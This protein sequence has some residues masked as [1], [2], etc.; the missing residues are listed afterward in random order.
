MPQSSPDDKLAAVQIEVAELGKAVSAMVEHS[1]ANRAQR[2]SFLMAELREIKGAQK[3]IPAQPIKTWVNGLQLVIAVVVGV[4]GVGGIVFGFG[5]TWSSTNGKIEGANTRIATV[6]SELRLRLDT[7]KMEMTQAD[8]I[9]RQQLAAH[10]DQIRLLHT[11]DQAANERMSQVYQSLA[12]ITVQNQN[13]AERMA[14]IGRRQDR[15]EARLGLSRGN[16]NAQP[17]GMGD[18]GL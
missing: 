6:E 8:A 18:N 13:L 5:Q 10:T 2:D 4:F 7:A 17:S 1:Q 15:L 3:A 11:T 14:E 16:Q 9:M 12:T